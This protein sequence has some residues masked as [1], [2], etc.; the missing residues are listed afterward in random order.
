VRRIL[1]SA[2]LLAV[3]SSPSFAA[4]SPYENAAKLEMEN[5]ATSILAASLCKGVRF[6]GDALIT[7]LTAAIV[8]IG[9]KRAEDSFFAAIRANIDEMSANGR[10]AWCAATR[11]AAKERDSELLTDDSNLGDGK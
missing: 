5:L 4:G 7:T 6:N 8:L 10:D 9:Q 2:Y 11:K 1:L 3:L